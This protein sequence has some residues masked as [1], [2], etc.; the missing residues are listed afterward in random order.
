MDPDGKALDVEDVF[1]ELKLARE[2]Y[3]KVG[4]GAEFVVQFIR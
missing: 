2:H 1:R 4:L 3:E